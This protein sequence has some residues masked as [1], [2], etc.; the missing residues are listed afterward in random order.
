MSATGMF[1]QNMARHV[2]WV[3]YPP[4]IGPIAVRPPAMPK[5]SASALPRSRSGN[6]F[7]TMARAAGNIERAAGTLE[8]A[9]ADDPTL[10]RRSRR[11]QAAHSRRDDEDDDADHTHLG[12]PED[13][14]ESPAEREQRREGDQ[15]TVDHPLDARRAEAELA[16]DARDGDGDDRLVDERHGDREDHRGEH[17]VSSLHAVPSHRRPPARRHRTTITA[18]APVGLR[19]TGHL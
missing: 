10:C 8:D 1:T 18:A 13:V 15:I 17:P 12:V 7:T 14:G 2:H 5:N 6:V 11:C 9:E 16:L 4:R 3:R 19:Q